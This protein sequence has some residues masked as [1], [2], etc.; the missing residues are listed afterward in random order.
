M[1]NATSHGA[2]ETTGTYPRTADP[3]LVLIGPA[4]AF[5]YTGLLRRVLC[6]CTTL[7]PFSRSHRTDLGAGAAGWPGCAAA[8]GF[9]AAG[10][11]GHR[12]NNCSY[13]AAIVTVL[14]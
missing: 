10:S 11:T 7:T 13:L 14:F 3:A 5:A 4:R 12:R 1:P 9:S 2:D 6:K 8:K